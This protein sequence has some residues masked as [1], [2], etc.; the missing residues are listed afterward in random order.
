[1]VLNARVR[2]PTSPLPAA[3]SST[4]KSPAATRAAA[5][6]RRSSGRVTNTPTMNANS[7]TPRIKVIRSSTV[8]DRNTPASRSAS[9][10]GASATAAQRSCGIRRKTATTSRPA[11]RDCTTGWPSRS[12]SS[13]VVA[14]GIVVFIRSAELPAELTTTRPGSVTR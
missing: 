11:E 1:M 3:G 12:T 5:S 9:A 2:Y 6:V 7:P 8:R 13:R 14:S 4:D 10:R